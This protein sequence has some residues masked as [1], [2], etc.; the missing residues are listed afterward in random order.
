MSL[1]PLLKQQFDDARQEGGQLD[2]RRLLHAISTAYAE[3]DEERR[4][5]V[6]SMRLLADETTAF[7]R[8]VRESAAAQL[9]AILDHV[10]DAI[11][12]VDDTGRIETLNTTGERVFGYGENDVRGQKLDL[13]IPSLARK[14]RIVEAL[15]EFATAVEDTQADLAPRETRGRHKNGTLFDAEIGVSKVRL[16][17]REMYIVCLRETTDRKAAE[18]AIRES[19]ARYRTLVE[20]APE[21]IVV[22][23]M[24]LGHFVECNENAVRFF[25]MTREELLH[26]GPQKISPPYQSDGSPSFG[27]ARGYLD[28]ALAGEAP[29]FEWLHRDALGHDIPCEVRL[30][31][32]PSSGRR[33]IRGSITDITERK[34]NE[35]LAVGD[36][37]VFERITSHADLMTTLEAVTETAEKVTP[38]AICAVSVYEPE[39]NVLFHVAGTRLPQPYLNAKRRVE[40]GPRNGSCAAA[41]F[42][43]RQVIVAEITRDALWE[44]VR[45][46]A[47]EAGLRACWSTPVRASDGRVLGTVAL[48]FRQPRSPLRRDFELMSRLTALAGIAIERKRSEEALRRSEA[49]YR[50]LF[51]NVIEGVYRSTADG[52]FEAV[53]PALVQ[54]LGYD[55]ADELLAIDDNRV[56]YAHASERDNV[57]STLHRDGLVRGAESQL[58]R[59]DGTLVTVQEN[60]RVIRGADDGIVGYEGTLTDITERK[61]AELQLY[62]EKEK[63]QV[64]LQSIGDAVIT[65]DASGRVEYL[66]PV[67]EDL[68]GWDS[69]EAYGRPIG[70]VFHVVSEATR[71]PVDSPI[72]RCLREGRVV[73]MVEPSVL[74]NR[75]GQEISVQDSAAPIRDRGGRLIG[76]VMVFH[77]VSQERRLQRALSYQATHDVLTGLINRREFELRLTDALHTARADPSI[78]HV[79]MFL[80]LDQFKVVN[81][82][83]GH[84]A[85]DRLLKQITSVLQTR[86]RATDTLARLGGDEFGVLLQDCTLETAQ[87]IGEELRQ[88]IRDF[89]FSWQDRVMNVGVSIGLAE[90]NAEHETLSTIMSAADVACYSAKESGRNRVHTYSE[91]QAPERLREMQWVS[92]INQACDEERFELYFQ[93]IVPIR[94]GVETTRQ[95]ELLLRMRDEAGRLVLPNEFIPAAERFNLMPAIDRW[96]VRQACRTLAHRRG[97]DGSIPPYCLTINVSTTTI[98]DEQFLDHVIAE[99]AAAEVSPGALCFELTETTA[100]TSLVAATHFIRELRKRGVRF[101]LDDF[102]SGLSSFLFLKNLPVDFVKIDGQF[103]HNVAQDAID[104]SMVDAITQIA[105]AMGICTVAERV[106]S[107]EVLEQLAIVGVQ[108]AQGHYIA[109][110]QPVSVLHELLASPMTVGEVGRKA[111]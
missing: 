107:A 59:R 9:Q 51:E 88:A 66:N 52:R 12:T 87:R 47:V 111:G 17:R 37:R 4:G 21:A 94:H 8:E 99:M 96:V 55:S 3:W 60:A 83:C 26:S 58:R 28:R 36:R 85:G 54:M 89:R 41:V 93:P 77:D 92:R 104:R 82:T 33:L 102:G 53:N 13:L 100:M 10:K 70:E 75:R 110:P 32:L 97:T 19:E 35:L 42:L 57:I 27:V 50:S 90:M 71:Q 106:D 86:I 103:V 6:R 34:R 73:D 24:D 84:A 79:V 23:D 31:R 5:V 1:H 25:K 91:G 64:T 65:T 80:D 101:S 56:I 46:P 68:T 108:Y 62:E 29:N 67:A 98:N 48:Y 74:I 63:A 16:D 76:V 72:V 40:I 14:P 30:V 18:A 69:R 38:D 43:Q 2:L 49:Q 20:H 11:L 15:E 95:F 109:S 44:H 78:R 39:A 7:T 45:V 22:L 61:R 81:D 105:G